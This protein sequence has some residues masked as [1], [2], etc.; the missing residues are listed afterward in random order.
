[1]AGCGLSIGGIVL[2]TWYELPVSLVFWTIAGLALANTG[3]EELPE[4]A[5]SEHRWL[6]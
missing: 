4:T 1:L 6:E 2:E 3:T 5:A